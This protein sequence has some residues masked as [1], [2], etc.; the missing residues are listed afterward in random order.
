[1]KIN[2][3]SD[4]LSKFLTNFASV[5]VDKWCNTAVIVSHLALSARI[6]TIYNFHRVFRHYTTLPRPFLRFQR[7]PRFQPVLARLSQSLRGQSIP[8]IHLECVVIFGN[9]VLNTT[10]SQ[11]LVYISPASALFFLLLL[12]SERYRRSETD[13]PSETAACSFP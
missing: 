6:F 1:M 12:F 3:E 5:R 10:P 13:F 11:R 9:K 8:L 2:Q 4:E 7:C